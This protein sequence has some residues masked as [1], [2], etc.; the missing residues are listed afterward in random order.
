MP[1]PYF[2]FIAQVFPPKGNDE[3]SA[4]PACPGSHNLMKHAHGCTSEGRSF[5]QT[6][7]TW[8]E[9]DFTL[10]IDLI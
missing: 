4:T 1:N 9:T 2:W 5:A 10:R 7:D 8:N 3:A 6:T